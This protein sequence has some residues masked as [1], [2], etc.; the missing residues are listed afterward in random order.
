ML[1]HPP[2]ASS[3]CPSPWEDCQGHTAET[4]GGWWEG[5]GSHLRE[6]QP[7]TGGAFLLSTCLARPPAGWMLSL[8]VWACSEVAKALSLVTG[9]RSEHLNYLWKATISLVENVQEKARA[10][11]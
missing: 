11:N 5:L 8:S 6:L 4:H 7:G 10:L 3:R 9:I 2:C 1:P